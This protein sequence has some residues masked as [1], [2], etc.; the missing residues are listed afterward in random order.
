MKRRKLQGRGRSGLDGRA[1]VQSAAA[2]VAAGCVLAGAAS[3]V[4]AASAAWDAGGGASTSWQNAL[5]W[6]PNTV[7][8]STSDVTFAGAV[9][10]GLLIDTS[11]SGTYA[12]NTILISTANA[13]FTS[14]FNICRLT[15]GDLTRQDVA[16]TEQNQILN[17]VFEMSDHGLWNVAGS[18][19]LTVAGIGDTDGGPA[20][21]RNVTKTGNGLLNVQVAEWGGTT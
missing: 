18:G 5:N 4:M 1:R 17:F 8:S 15:T 9:A 16:G 20:T 14:T 11:A 19:M 2:R 13:F 10:N 21:A 12:A 7:P 3:H 6:N